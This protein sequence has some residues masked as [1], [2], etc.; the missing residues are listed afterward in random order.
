[1]ILLGFCMCD[2]LNNIECI[3]I[4]LA[5]IKASVSDLQA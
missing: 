1:M 3:S 5:D 4:Y 2:T